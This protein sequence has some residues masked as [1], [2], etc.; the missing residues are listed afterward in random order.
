MDF[1]IVA[2][3]VGLVLAIVVG[4]IVL[5]TVMNTIREGE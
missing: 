2:V 3:V 4:G 1:T 5:F